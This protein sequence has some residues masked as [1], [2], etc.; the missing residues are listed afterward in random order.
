MSHLVMNKESIHED[1]TTANRV[2]GILKS[3]GKLLGVIL[4][5]FCTNNPRQCKIQDKNIFKSFSL[6]VHNKVLVKTFFPLLSNTMA[7]VLK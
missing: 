4:I 7:L 6:N 1:A 5:I 2:V 3:E